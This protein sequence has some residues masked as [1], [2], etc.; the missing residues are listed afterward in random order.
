MRRS[1][2][3]GAG[4]Q[5]REI[6][7]LVRELEGDDDVVEDGLENASQNPSYNNTP[8]QSLGSSPVSERHSFVPLKHRH[9]S[10]LSPK[11]SQHNF[12]DDQQQQ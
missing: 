3:N 6:R 5:L 9:G 10:N 1:A 2:S 11:G 8:S 7:A 12:I 4:T